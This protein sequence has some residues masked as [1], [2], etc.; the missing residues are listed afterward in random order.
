[1]RDTGI[2]ILV[3]SD[4]AGGA[5]LIAQNMVSGAKNGAIRAMDHG[6]AIGPDLAS[7]TSTDPRVSVS[8][9]VVA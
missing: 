4:P 9:N 2:G 1:V 6:Q 3:S 8:G 7:S 5:C